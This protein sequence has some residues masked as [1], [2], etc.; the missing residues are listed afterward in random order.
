MVN[1]QKVYTTN[2]HRADGIFLATRTDPTAPKHR[3]ITLLLVDFKTPG[4]TRRP[5][6]MMGKGRTNEVFFDNVRGPVE[7]RVG[8]ENRAWYYMMTTLTYERAG[9]DRIADG[10]RTFEDLVEYARTTKRNGRPMAQ[11]V[12]LRHRLAEMAIEFD[13]GR[14]LCYR[15]AWLQDNG[16]TPWYEGS[17]SKAFSTEMQQRL[18]RLGIQ[19][20]GLYGQLEEGS[21]H[22][23]LRGWITKTYQMCIG[24]TIGGGTSETQRNIIAWRG[25]DLPR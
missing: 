6:W 10:Q 25:L 9:I 20:L 19:V 13:V 22:A 11:D 24:R 4:V 2:G 17:V 7:N 5:L 16:Q 21:P 12:N 3:G 23:H 1:G 14:L 18:A 8:E 15:V